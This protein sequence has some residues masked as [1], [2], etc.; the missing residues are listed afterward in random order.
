MSQHVQEAAKRVPLGAFVDAE[1]RQALKQLAERSDR[2]VSSLVRLAVGDLLAK[3]KRAQ[4]LEQTAE[5]RARAATWRKL[6]MP[7]DP[8]EAA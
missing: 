2:S 1:Q 3:P 6:E 8:K 5:V 4:L 7:D